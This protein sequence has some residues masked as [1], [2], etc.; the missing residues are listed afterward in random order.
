MRETPCRVLKFESLQHCHLQET[1]Y[2]QSVCHGRKGSW[3]PGLCFLRFPFTNLSVLSR[4]F[5]NFNS[6]SSGLPRASCFLSILQFHQLYRTRNGVGIRIVLQSMYYIHCLQFVFKFRPRRKRM[7]LSY[8]PRSD[9]QLCHAMLIPILLNLVRQFWVPRTLLCCFAILLL[10][11][12][13]INGRHTVC[14]S[15]LCQEFCEPLGSRA[16]GILHFLKSHRPM[17][18]CSKL[19]FPSRQ[20]A[21][22]GSITKLFRQFASTSHTQ[23][24][25][26]NSKL[27]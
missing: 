19:C 9:F 13:L 22:A 1:L 21:Y 20:L 25:L 15:I 23:I 8:R 7:T 17:V 16:I 14:V 12:G 11:H 26:I 5:L 2:F 4:E 6:L 10:I 18:K 3:F 24:A 27:Q